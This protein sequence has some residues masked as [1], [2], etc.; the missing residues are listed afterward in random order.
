[1]GKWD[2]AKD[3]PKMYISVSELNRLGSYSEEEWQGKLE[4]EQIA[5]E[6]RQPKPRIANPLWDSFQGSVNRT[7][8]RIEKSF[9]ALWLIIP[10]LLI[11]GFLTGLCHVSIIIALLITAGIGP[12]DILRSSGLVGPKCKDKDGKEIDDLF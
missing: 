3:I 7:F 9:N 5:R 8:T 12:T 11:V 4:R 1:M 2:F 10:P 6:A